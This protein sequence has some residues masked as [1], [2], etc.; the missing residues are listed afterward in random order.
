MAV[1]LPA[2]TLAAVVTQR[3]A[4]HYTIILVLGAA[5]L[6]A[7]GAHRLAVG[8]SAAAL[9]LALIMTGIFAG[10]TTIVAKAAVMEDAEPVKLE[11]RHPDLPIVVSSGLAFVQAWYYATPELRSRLLFVSDRR[12]AWRY[13]R[14]EQTNAFIPYTARFFH[15]RFETFDHLRRARP[16]FLLSWTNEDSWLLPALREAGARLDLV[17]VQGDSYLF[18]VTQKSVADAP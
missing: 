10:H 4:P 14:N 9:V 3:L 7:F 15:W 8:S 16:R 6:F 2:F 5:V 18:L 17:E 12:T 1:P 13:L 11:T